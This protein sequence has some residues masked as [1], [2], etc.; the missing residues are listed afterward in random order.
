MK[1]Q[2]L[3][4]NRLVWRATQDECIPSPTLLPNEVLAQGYCHEFFSSSAT[5]IQNCC[6]TSALLPLI[7]DL[8]GRQDKASNKRFVVFLGEDVWPTPFALRDSLGT[9]L[10]LTKFIFI[11]PTSQKN[12]CRALEI[13]AR[14]SSVLAVVASLQ[15]VSFAFT[16]KLYLFSKDSHAYTFLFRDIRELN[17]KSAAH[18]RWEIAPVLSKTNFPSWNITLRYLKGSCQGEKKWLMEG[19]NEKEVFMHL[20]SQLVGGAHTE[21]LAHARSA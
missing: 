9:E 10:P 12:K 1:A 6:P 13:L 4:N 21:E 18:S 3:I 15:K 7:G 14:S 17:Q 2:W 5:K 19:V 11:N 16:Q 8:Q 20:L